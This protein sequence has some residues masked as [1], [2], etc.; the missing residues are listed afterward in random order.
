MSFITEELN[1][2]KEI[3]RLSIP[4]KRLKEKLAPIPSTFESLRR[5]WFWELLQNA[6]DYNDEV[7]VR[8]ELF[9]D[10]VIFSH[11]GLPFRAIDTENLISP[12]SGK[13]D[14]EIQAKDPIGQFGTGLFQRIFY[15]QR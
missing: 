3:Q 11:N 14:E 2:A 8:M 6:S 5:R 15:Q 10:K 4:A 9:P 1:D 7:S 13:D 12:D